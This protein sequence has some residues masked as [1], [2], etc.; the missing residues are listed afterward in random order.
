MLSPEAASH[1][2]L[3][4]IKRWGNALCTT[5]QDDSACSYRELAHF[6]IL[7][8]PFYVASQHAE[9]DYFIKAPAIPEYHRR[10]SILEIYDRLSRHHAS[11]S[12]TMRLYISPLQNLHMKK[13]TTTFRATMPAL[14]PLCGSTSRFRHNYRHHSFAISLAE[15]TY[16]RYQL[17]LTF[18]FGHLPKAIC[19]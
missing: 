16:H 18:T 6:D 2:S 1:R 14:R 17:S 5:G 8:N 13:P 3:D 9:L 12:P 19:R 7:F 11:A 4:S 15:F 10:E